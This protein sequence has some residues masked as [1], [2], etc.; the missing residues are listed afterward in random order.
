MQKIIVDTN[1]IVSALIQRSYPYLIMSQLFIDH[2]IEI[3]ISDELMKEYYDVLGRK[4]FSKYPDFIS[5][6]TAIL[7]DI[8]NKSA[9]YVPTVQ[10]QILTDPDD[11]KLLELAH[12]SKADYLITGNSNHFTI[13]YYKKTKIVSPKEYWEL[14]KPV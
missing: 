8:E 4:K 6:A 7:T 13:N 1:V 2:E 11:D 9:R 3:C 5:G 10:L 14:Y 12:V